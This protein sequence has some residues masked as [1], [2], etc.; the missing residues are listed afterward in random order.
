VA[1]DS[2]PADDR[3]ADVHDGHLC[4]HLSCPQRHRTRHGKPGAVDQVPIVGTR[5]QCTVCPGQRPRNGKSK[6]KKGAVEPSKGALEPSLSFCET[7][8]KGHE[9][10]HPMM[11]FRT[12]TEP[13]AVSAKAK[14]SW[15]VLEVLSH[16]TNGRLTQYD[17]NWEGPFWHSWHTSAELG[18]D[19]MIEQ[20]WARVATNKKGRNKSRPRG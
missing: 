1:G 14:I 2:I 8:A 20:Y 10:S 7:C 9:A 11:M 19:E 18:N 3:P 6:V 4:A 15:P 13:V 5:Y 12:S 16:R 17:I